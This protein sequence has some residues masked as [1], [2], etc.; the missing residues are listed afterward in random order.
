MLTVTGELSWL[1]QRSRKS[2]NPSNIDCHD[3]DMTIAA[4]HGETLT[5]MAYPKLFFDE[6]GPSN[7]ATH[8]SRGWNTSL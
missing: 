3:Y 5:R 1:G 2:E 7:P 4:E 6:E 8:R